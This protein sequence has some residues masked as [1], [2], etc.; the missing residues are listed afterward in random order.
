VRPFPGTLPCEHA[1]YLVTAD[2]TAELARVQSFRR[3]LLDQVA[4][5]TA[6]RST[7]D[8]DGST[9]GTPRRRRRRAIDRDPRPTRLRRRSR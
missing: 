4:A 8:G 6:S 5:T 7:L 2:A 3:W 1:Y 9:P